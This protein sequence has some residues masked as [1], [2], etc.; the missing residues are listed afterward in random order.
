MKRNIIELLL[1]FTSQ[2]SIAEQTGGGST[3]SDTSE[4]SLVSI[5]EKVESWIDLGKKEGKRIHLLMNKGE[6]IMSEVLLVYG[7]HLADPNYEASRNDF[8]TGYA[9]GWVNPQTGKVRKSEAKAVFDA[10]VMGDTERK[11]VVGYDKD[12]KAPIHETRKISEWLTAHESLAGW[13]QYAGLIRLAKELRGPSTNAGAGGGARRKTVVTDKQQ[14]E[15]E[16][17]IPLMNGQQVTKVME[18]AVGRL[19]QA[20]NFQAIL[21]R[22]MQ[23]SCNQ[24]KVKTDGTTPMGKAHIEAASE[25]GDLI[26]AHLA[27]IASNEAR[28]AGQPAPA[29][30]APAEVAATG[31]HG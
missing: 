28:L 19:T 22:E 21:F 6:A 10:F 1:G 20:P 3:D 27:V 24:I 25:I 8:L 4:K 5:P 11:L 18:K 13:Q 9:S 30:P 12:S 29:A 31:T 17:R 7:A 16:E 14:G 15:V 2:F 23:F 26:E